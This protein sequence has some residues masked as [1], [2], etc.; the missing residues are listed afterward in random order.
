MSALNVILANHYSLSNNL[1]LPDCTS[2]QRCTY[3]LL[4]ATCYDSTSASQQNITDYCRGLRVI[5]SDV[6][7]TFTTALHIDA[8]A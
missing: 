4:V 5:P 2:A 3:T 1:I 7:C 8:C 6:R